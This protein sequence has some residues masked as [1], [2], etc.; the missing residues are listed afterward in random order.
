MTGE[1][2]DAAELVKRRRMTSPN[3]ETAATVIPPKEDSLT[4]LELFLPD[5]AAEAEP[6]SG[7]C[8]PTRP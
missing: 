3:S 7:T 5:Q 8:S 1:E 2:G 6:S 4:D